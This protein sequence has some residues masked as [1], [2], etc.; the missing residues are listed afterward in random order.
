LPDVLARPGEPWER[1]EILEIG[2]G[3]TLT[4][5]KKYEYVGTEKK[6]DKTLDKLS[7]KALEVTYKQDPAANTPLK[8]IKSNLKVDSS[9]GAILFDREEGYVVSSKGKTRIKGDITFSANGMEIGGTLDLR[10]ET[11]VELMPP[12]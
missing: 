4:F 11:N 1:T 3:Q 12:R 6:G 10:L 2:G 9:E 5:H 7:S 8:A